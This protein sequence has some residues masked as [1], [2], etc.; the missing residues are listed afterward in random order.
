MNRTLLAL[1]IVSLA[2][3]L[4]L[5]SCGRGATP[6]STP[7]PTATT[8]KLKPTDTPVPA[9][10]TPTP[11]PTATP[12]PTYTALPA[13]ATPGEVMTETAMPTDTPQSTATAK[14]HKLSPMVEIPGGSFIFGSDKGEPDEAPA[15]EMELPAF[16]ID[17]FEVTNAD[18]RAF[19][20]ATGY[21]TDAEARGDRGWQAYA[22]GKDRHPVVKVS[23]N[24]AVAFCQWAGKRLPTEA[25]WEKAAR[26]T[27]G[28]IYPWDN[29]WDPT[30]VNGKDYGLRGTAV[31]GSF[32]AGASPYGAHDMAGNVWE[33]TADWYKAYPG[34]PYQDPYY[35]ERFRVLRGGGWFETQENLRTANRSANIPEAANDDI[36]FRCAR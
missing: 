23:W 34:S 32:G 5:A 20:E 4:M 36:G 15:Q 30:K 6:T 17:M 7:E 27:D 2:G 16:E 19:V 1:L 33:W 29:Q 26:G 10:P 18:F 11:L 28:R 3:V 31:V 13:T 21:V 8:I 22:E 12:I 14:P 9:P 25:E 35:G 24:D